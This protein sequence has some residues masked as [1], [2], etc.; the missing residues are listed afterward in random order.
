MNAH[1][2]HLKTTENNWFKQGKEKQQ[3][4]IKYLEEKRKRDL[5]KHSE[6]MQNS[7]IKDGADATEASPDQ[8]HYGKT[9]R[10]FFSSK[11]GSVFNQSRITNGYSPNIGDSDYDLD[12]KLQTFH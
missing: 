4:I 9:D 2:Q 11:R 8:K 6:S 7:M 3:E 12:S 1:H 10:M 5:L